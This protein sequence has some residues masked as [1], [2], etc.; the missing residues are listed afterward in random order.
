[1]VRTCTLTCQNLAFDFSG[2]IEGRCLR[3]TINVGVTRGESIEH[4]SSRL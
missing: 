1:M 4:A 2:V 3:K